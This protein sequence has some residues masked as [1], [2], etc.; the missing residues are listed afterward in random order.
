MGSSLSRTPFTYCFNKPLLCLQK[1][2]HDPASFCY[3]RSIFSCLDYHNNPPGHPVSPSRVA[4]KSFI[5]HVKSFPSSAQKPPV[6][7]Q[8]RKIP[9][10][11]STQICPMLAAASPLSPLLT[12]HSVINSFHSNPWPASVLLLKPNIPA[13]LWAWLPHLCSSLCWNLTW[14]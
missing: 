2:K 6:T 5:K 1:C 9:G 12:P 7:S 13:D 3:S 8:L 4:G 11:H 10:E 14:K